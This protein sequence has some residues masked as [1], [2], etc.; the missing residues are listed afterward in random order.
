MIKIY[1]IDKNLIPIRSLLS[2]VIHESLVEAFEYPIDKRFQKFFPMEKENFIAQNRSDNYIMIEI[3]IFEG[4][5]IEAKKKLIRLLFK[6]ISE[7][8]GIDVS[9]IEITIYETPKHNWGIRGVPGDELSLN[10]RV[11]V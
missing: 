7:K 3:G 11:E 1:G 9:D 6:N 10:Y 8:I 5:S 2:N 4:R